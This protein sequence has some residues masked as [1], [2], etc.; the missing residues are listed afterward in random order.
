MF[1]DASTFIE[2]SIEEVQHTLVE[3]F[4]LVFIV[5]FVFL[6]SFRMTLIPMITI[7]VALIGTFLFMALFGFSINMLTMLSLV[8]A[9]GIVVDDAIIVVE[10]V[11]RNLLETG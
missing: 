11:E 10:N 2:A 8:L 7:P 9:I 6:Q 5:V 3:A 4:I 1:Y